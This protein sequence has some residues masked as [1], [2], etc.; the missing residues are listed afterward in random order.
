MTQIETKTLELERTIDAPIEKV[1]KALTDPDLLAQWFA[2]GPMTATVHA[3]DAKVGGQYEIAMTGPTPEG[4]EG[5]HTCTGTFK[6]VTDTRVAMTFNWTEEPM[7]NETDLVF[8]LEPVEG[9]TRLVLRHSGFPNEEAAKQH[10]EGWEGCLA[11]LP[12]AV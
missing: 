10:T 8:D 1:R 11:K 7:P 12:A 9:G 3:C 2:P 4:G 6:E 5:T